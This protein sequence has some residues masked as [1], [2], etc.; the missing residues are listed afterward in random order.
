[1]EVG[2]DCDI[3]F[4]TFV[5]D[6]IGEETEVVDKIKDFVRMLLLLMVAK[7]LKAQFREERFQQLIRWFKAAADK[8]EPARDEEVRKHLPGLIPEFHGNLQEAS[9]ENPHFDKGL[10]ESLSAAVQNLQNKISSPLP[11]G[12]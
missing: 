1:M 11:A 2:V 8:I 12:K 9:R 3:D 6:R 7:L 4:V 5:L 10:L